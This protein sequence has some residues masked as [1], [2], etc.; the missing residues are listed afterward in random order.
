MKQIGVTTIA[1]W[2]AEQL[3]KDMTAYMEYKGKLFR[4]KRIKSYNGSI[5]PVF[6]TLL[7]AKIG[8]EFTGTEDIFT[9]E[10]SV[11]LTIDRDLAGV[12]IANI[13]DAVEPASHGCWA[14]QTEIVR[15]AALDEY[16]ALQRVAADQGISQSV[17][18]CG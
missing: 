2:M 7:D 14:M 16:Y 11:F 13:I 12:T 4:L 17:P 15:S 8:S 1:R 3:P 10:S 9:L 6:A 5:R 18:W